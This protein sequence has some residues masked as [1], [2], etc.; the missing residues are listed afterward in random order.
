M[1]KKRKDGE[2]LAFNSPGKLKSQTNS[3]NSVAKRVSLSF[4]TADDLLM[5]KQERSGKNSL[6]YASEIKNRLG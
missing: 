1:G 2:S 5:N 4:E 3:V 6:A